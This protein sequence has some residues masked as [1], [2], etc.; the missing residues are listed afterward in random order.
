MEAKRFKGKINLRKPQ[1]PHFE[2]ALLLTLTK[3]KFENKLKNKTKLELCAFNEDKRAE[4]DNPYERFVAAEIL[5]H[6]QAS[7]FVLFCH[8][9]TMSTEDAMEVKRLLIKSDMQM[10]IYG[11]KTMKMALQGT[12]YEAVLS[13]YFSH[14]AIVFSPQADIKKCLKICRKFPSLLPLGKI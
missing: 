5:E 9:N 13:F 3:P 2:R 7:K 12:P 14:N 6:F 11:R 1:K 10:E 4:V 8:R